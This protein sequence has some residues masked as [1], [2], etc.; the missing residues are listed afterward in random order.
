MDE[1]IEVE[2]SIGTYKFVDVGHEIIFLGVEH[3]FDGW[4]NGEEY[5]SVS[6]PVYNE[7]RKK[8]DREIKADLIRHG[9]NGKTGAEK[10]QEQFK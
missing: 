10:L 2:Q 7:L 1:R 4:Q 6:T 8:V 3:V 5:G 9:V